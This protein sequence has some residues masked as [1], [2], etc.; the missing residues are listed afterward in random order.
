MDLINKNVESIDPAMVTQIR[1]ADGTLMPQAAM[2]T[3]H[4]DNPDL[5]AAMEDVITE[6]IRLGY[7]HLD[8]ATAYQNEEVVG[9]AISKAIESG[10]VIREELFVLSKLWNKNMK[11]EEVIPALDQTLKDLGLEYLDMYLVHWPWPNYHEPGS[12]GDAVNAHAVSI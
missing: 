8:C 11:P 3:F 4:S 12:A 7:R 1:L 9:R 2:G 6:A 10:L 5:E